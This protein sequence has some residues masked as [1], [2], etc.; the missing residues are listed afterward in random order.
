MLTE[1]CPV[2]PCHVDEVFG[3]KALEDLFTK[4]LTLAKMAEQLQLSVQE[5]L[6]HCILSARTAL[7]QQ[8]THDVSD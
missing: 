7:Q 3:F 6:K 5:Y 4:C 1:L 2:G 8:Q